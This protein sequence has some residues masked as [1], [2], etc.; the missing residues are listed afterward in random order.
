MELGAIL[1]RPQHPRCD[2]C[3]LAVL[4]K[5]RHLDLTN[6]LPELVVPP[7]VTA[8]ETVALVLHHGETGGV[9]VNQGMTSTA[10]RVLVSKRGAG[11]TRWAGLWEFPTAEVSSG[12][13]PSEAAARLFAN[14]LRTSTPPA[15]YWLALRHSVTRYRI[16][17]RV[18]RAAVSR[19]AEGSV[20]SS[21]E[22][23]WAT[24][25]ELQ[26]LAMSAP[27]RKLA[28]LL[29]AGPTR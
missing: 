23:R 11:A 25:D 5:A 13:T 21:Q 26:A 14:T 12:E 28:G 24:V 20:E 4:C 2:E 9:E 8:V 10:G 6:Q 15:E 22:A 17:L 29:A 27:H 3:P 18:F 1:C 7:P 19:E 16:T